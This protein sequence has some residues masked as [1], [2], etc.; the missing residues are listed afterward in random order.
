MLLGRQRL[1]AQLMMHRDLANKGQ[2]WGMVE[3]ARES[4]GLVT[5]AQAAIRISHVPQCVRT[6]DAGRHRRV[7]SSVGTREISILF[8]VV[9]FCRSLC[10]R[11]R[12]LEIT[13]P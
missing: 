10:V 12:G 4:Q 6:E 9:Q 5:L 8:R 1:A 7:V 13:N 3:Y 11:D 2:S